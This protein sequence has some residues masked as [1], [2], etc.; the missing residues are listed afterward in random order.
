MMARAMGITLAD[1]VTDRTPEERDEEERFRAALYV[2]KH[3]VL[4][5]AKPRPP[6]RKRLPTAA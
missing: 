3:G 2:Q 1:L 4:P 6:S 5:D